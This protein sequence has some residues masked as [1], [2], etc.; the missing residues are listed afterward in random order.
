MAGFDK[1]WSVRRTLLCRNSIFVVSY[2]FLFVEIR[3]EKVAWK[4]QSAFA[5]DYIETHNVAYE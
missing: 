4:I 3:C 1:R 5:L 2:V